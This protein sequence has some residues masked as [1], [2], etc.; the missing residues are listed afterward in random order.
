MM[1][2]LGVGRLV[3]DPEL[4]QTENS[5]VSQFSMAV[6]EYRKINGERKKFTH[7]LDFVVWDKGAELI[8]EYVRKGDQ[9]E[10][11]ATP[12]QEKWNDK[13]TGAPRSKLVFRVDEFKFMDSRK[14]QVEEQETETEVEPEEAPF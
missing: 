8:C 6:D 5:C 3:R 13:E 9:L 12:R 11:L 2:L 7:F 14:S 4:K 1:K 10:V